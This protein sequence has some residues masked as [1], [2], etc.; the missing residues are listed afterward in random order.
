[1][2]KV[3]LVR[4]PKSSGLQPKRNGYGCLNG[5][6]PAGWGPAE[7]QV[8]NELIGSRAR[9]LNVPGWERPWTHGGRSPR[10]RRNGN[11]V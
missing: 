10:I 11:R 9:Y 7:N 4:P 1:M 6:E 8:V 2:G 3:P 5:K